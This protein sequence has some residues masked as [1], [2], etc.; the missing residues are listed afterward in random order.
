MTTY[1]I[2]DLHLGN[3]HCDRAA[4]GAFLD[5]LP[6]E[7][8][9]LIVG[10]L[11]DQRYAAFTEADRQILTQ[12]QRLDGQCRLTWLGGN[13]DLAYGDLTEVGL[14]IEAPWLKYG[15]TLCL[16]GHGRADPLL[17]YQRWIQLL[18]WGWDRFGSGIHPSRI[19]NRI[20]GAAWFL[21]A[22]ARRRLGDAAALLEC[23][24]VVFGHTHLPDDTTQAG[25]R[26]VNVGSWVVGPPYR[27]AVIED[28]GSVR[29]DPWPTTKGATDG[30]PTP[31]RDAS[32][33]G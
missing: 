3:P 15:A 2:S 31:T 17:R 11:L 28:E 13:H 12:L 9:L 25:I 21:K 33:P 10:D 22:E 20:P 26:F 1:A 18:A 5:A 7:A 29:I 8:D 27:Y 14:T 24:T 19:V 16:H 32:G 23:T 4:L 6:T 30:E